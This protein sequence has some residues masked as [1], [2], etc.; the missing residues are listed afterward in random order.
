MCIDMYKI[1]IIII[2]IIIRRP[3][4]EANIEER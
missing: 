1:I 2:I 3:E 4:K